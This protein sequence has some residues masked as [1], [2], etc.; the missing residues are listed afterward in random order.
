MEY[1]RCS[2]RAFTIVEMLAVIAIMFVLAAMILPTL[3]KA[4]Q[5][6]RKASCASNIRC[7]A[8]ANGMYAC[9]HNGFYVVAADDIW[10]TNLHRWHGQRN[11]ANKP[12]DP[13]RSPLL[14]YMANPQLKECPSYVKGVDYSD[15]PGQGAAFEAGCG[16]Y[17]YNASYIGG[18]NDR[19]G[20]S[21]QATRTSAK[22]E[23][24]AHASETVMFTDSAYVAGTGKTRAK[25]AYSFCEPPFWDCGPPIGPI[26]MSP[27]PSIDFRHLGQT[28]VAWVDGHVNSQGMSFSASYQ[29]HSL[30]TGEEAES[31][32]IGWFG[33]QS[34]DLFDL[35]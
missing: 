12:F 4:K 3:G 33:P 5:L 35:K 7:L 11:N 23:N 20:I 26:D 22:I 1:T 24:V 27:D 13:R 25:I 31:Q 29:T 8:L 21:D 18:R 14:P 34:N 28:N 9:D 30:I 2:S 10:G 17:G 6:T 32:G 16:G 19:Y 15:D